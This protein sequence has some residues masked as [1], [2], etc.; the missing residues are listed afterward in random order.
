MERVN[1]EDMQW[2]EPLPGVKLKRVFEGENMNILLSMITPGTRTEIHSHPQEQLD[3]LIEG[4]LVIYSEQYNEEFVASAGDVIHHPAG[5]A[6]G[7]EN[8]SEKAVKLIEV[9]SPVRPAS[10]LRDLED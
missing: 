6:H 4:E 1:S 9:F 10:Y 7:G 2:D 5:I 8:C 3:Y